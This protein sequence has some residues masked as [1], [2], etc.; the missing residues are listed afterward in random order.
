MLSTKTKMAVSTWTNSGYPWS[1][2]PKVEV[3]SPTENQSVKLRKTFKMFLIEG[4]SRWKT[5]KM[6]I[7]ECVAFV[8]L[9]VPLQI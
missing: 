2:K 3:S 1:K 9:L 5:D 7:L 6:I 8:F 4:K